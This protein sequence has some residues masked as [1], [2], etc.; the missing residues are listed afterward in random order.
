M[1]ALKAVAVEWLDWAAR[2]AA[3]EPQEFFTRR[4]AALHCLKK[5]YYFE[6][7]FSYNRRLA[8]AMLLVPLYFVY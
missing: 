5:P 4:T 1:E 6:E 3:K 7:L 8:C 2:Y